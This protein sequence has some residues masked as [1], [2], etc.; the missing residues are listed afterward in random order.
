MKSI[1]ETVGLD[2]QVPVIEVGKEPGTI[3]E[4]SS[5]VS[6]DE[7]ENLISGRRGATGGERTSLINTTVGSDLGAGGHEA[8]PKLGGACVPFGEDS[9]EVWI[10]VF[11]AVGHGTTRHILE[12]RLEGKGNKHS[13]GICF[14]K[15]LNGLDHGV[16]NIG[17]SNTILKRT[18]TFGHRF[19]PG[20]H[21]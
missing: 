14:S 11:N 20:S 15:I 18:S 21:D 6:Q 8:H 9:S 10:S 7:P 2:V 3:I 16:G 5:S 17:S 4:Q 12:S 1:I 19:F 13:S